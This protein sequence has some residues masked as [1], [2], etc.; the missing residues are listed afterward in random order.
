[1][2]PENGLTAIIAL[3][4]ALAGGLYLAQVLWP[5]LRAIGSA[6]QADAD[7]RTSRVLGERAH[8]EALAA[9]A[10]APR[11]AVFELQFLRTAV[12]GEQVQALFVNRGMS[13]M[14]VQVQTSWGGAAFIEPHDVLR[15]GESGFLSF[16]MP[17]ESAAGAAVLRVQG[18]DMRGHRFRASYTYTPLDRQ[19]TKS[20]RHDT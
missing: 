5:Y 16:A 3:A 14:N 17:E 9:E 11:P 4:A 20:T 2:W 7:L 10:D 15:T 6:S 13:V 1:M 18:D 12:V 8:I 19:I